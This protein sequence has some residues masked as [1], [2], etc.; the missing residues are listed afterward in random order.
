MVGGRLLTT[1]GVIVALTG[2]T[3]VAQADDAGGKKKHH[4]VHGR[5]TDVASDGSA[6]TVEIRPH[7]KKN[8]LAPATPPAAVEK[9]FKVDKDTKFVFVS[10]KKGE[11]EFTPATFADVHKGERVVV[12]FRTGQSDLADRVAIVKHKKAATQAVQS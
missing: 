3:S 10:G 7:Q 12:V 8:A 1:I 11:R 2:F 6:I 4:A 5:V 9:K